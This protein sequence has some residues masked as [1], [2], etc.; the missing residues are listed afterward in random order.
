LSG[1]AVALSGGGHRAALFGLGVLLYLVDADKHRSVTSVASVSGGSL[2]NGYVAQGVDYSN[3]T[4][5]QFWAL[6]RSL[7]VQIGRRGTLWA[8]PLTW[9]YLALLALWALATLVGVWFLPIELGWRLLVFFAALLVLA[10]LASLRGWICARSFARTLFS[11]NGKPTPL[12]A[13][14]RPVDHVLCATDLHAGEHAYFSGRFVCSYRFGFG[15]AGDLALHDAVQ[16]SAAYPGGFP[17]RWLRTSRHA[18]V[19]P[20]EERAAETKFMAL[21][22]GGAY[23]NLGDEWAQGVRERNRRWAS[24]NPSLAEPDE[25]VVVNSSGPMGWRRMDALRLP[26]LGELL[27]L[28]RDIDVLYDTTTSTRR[29]WL[30]DTFVNERG[31]L[32]GAI[33]QITQSPFHVAGRFA[34]STQDDDEKRRALAVLA[35]LGDTKSEWASVAAANRAVKTT[36][37]KLGPDVAVRL[38]LHGYVLAMANLHVLLDYP[39]LPVPAAERFDEWGAST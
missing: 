17:A 22:D 30:F 37:S 29:R 15:K 18:F 23:D 35:A 16:A 2:T 1:I 19:Q 32:R 20:A 38:V 21:V 28:K 4:Q 5:E 8:S 24:L 9:V 6:A 25:L 7:T 26:V 10:W 36:L 3:V 27:T 13:T 39:L 11:P 34:E 14:A 31:A 33:V 12:A